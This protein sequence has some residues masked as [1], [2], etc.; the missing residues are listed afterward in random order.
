MFIALSDVCALWL[1]F[2]TVFA[3]VESVHESLP[4]RLGDGSCPLLADC[5]E[6]RFFFRPSNEIILDD[7]RS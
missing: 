7:L 4:S 3:N 2:W 5:A 1:A 6:E